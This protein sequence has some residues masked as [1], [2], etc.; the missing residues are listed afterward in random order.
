MGEKK[1]Y[2]EMFG[3]FP[4]T[5]Q[6]VLLTILSDLLSN[7]VKVKCYTSQ[8]R[9]VTMKLVKHQTEKY[10]Q[11]VTKLTFLSMYWYVYFVTSLIMLI[12]TSKHNLHVFITHFWLDKT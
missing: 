6:L 11:L 7:K 9:Y 1:K 10:F 12:I 5:D 3:S 2:I 4:S 8:V